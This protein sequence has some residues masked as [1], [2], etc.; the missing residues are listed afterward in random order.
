MSEAGSIVQEIISQKPVGGGGLAWCEHPLDKNIGTI[1]RQALEYTKEHNDHPKHGAVKALDLLSHEN[2]SKTTQRARSALIRVHAQ[3]TK[4]EST[5][6]LPTYILSA[7]SLD[8]LADKATPGS[9]L[10]RV[11]VAFEQR[12]QERS[13][14]MKKESP[15]TTQNPENWANDWTE[16]IA[17][18]TVL[19]RATKNQGEKVGDTQAINHAD[20]LARVRIF[21]ILFDDGD[22]GGRISTYIDRMKSMARYRKAQINTSSP[23]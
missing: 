14:E 20:E 12:L 1:T 10:R 7:S 18:K 16:L 19:A 9:N 2:E 15:E 11:I 23:S 3:L 17:W 8:G 5:A 6:E 22:T 21:N 13:E 4:Y